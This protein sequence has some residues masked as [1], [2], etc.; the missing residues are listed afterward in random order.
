MKFLLLENIDEVKYNGVF[1]SQILFR[2]NLPL[3]V[4]QTLFLKLLLFMRI[5]N[6]IL[7]F[8]GI[9]IIFLNNSQDL[10][11]NL[12]QKAEILFS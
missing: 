2:R 5:D 11:L 3:N 9:I 7:L 6:L 12:S 8:M 10:I 1:E 4:F